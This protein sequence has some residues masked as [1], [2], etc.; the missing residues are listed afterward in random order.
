MIEVH[1]GLGYYRDVGEQVEIL[2]PLHHPLVAVHE[3]MPSTS[4]T[5]EVWP[6][7]E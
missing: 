2:E 1:F 3:P 6:A 7:W 5:F 4:D